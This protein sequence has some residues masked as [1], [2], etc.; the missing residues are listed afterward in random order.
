MNNVSALIFPETAPANTV[1]A[2][3]LLFFDTLSFYLP[4]EPA[5]SDAGENGLF[6]SLCS[7]YAPA[8]LGEDL[9]RFRRLLRDLETSRP[10]E[11]SRL[12]SAA[13]APVATVLVRDRDETSAAG[14]YTALHKDAEKI[15]YNSRKERLWQARLLLKLAEVL[16]RREAEV[17]EGL[18]LVSSAEQQV[19]AALGGPDETF[20]DELN[21]LDG[22]GEKLAQEAGDTPFNKP[23]PPTSRQLVNLRVKAWAELYL[24]DKTPSPPLAL[25]SANPESGAILLDGYENIWRRE[26]RKLFSLAMPAI[27]INDA[28]S[29]DRF[30]A[31]RESFRAA[32]R[33]R[34][35]YF[36]AILQEIASAASPETES[37]GW[38]A[39]AI[40]NASDWGKMLGDHFPGPE[41]VQ[42][43]DF[44]SLPG[45]S[46]T[47][48]FQRLFHLP[49]SAPVDSRPYPEA[50]LAIL[51]T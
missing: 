26:P 48:L 35:E 7:G 24:T 27:Q 21:A 34:L 6:G 33:T 50:I 32:A 29:V 16:D 30:L 39:M 9:S 31:L 3:L 2:R 12:F 19:F 14:V 38:H 42:K 5:A 22:S 41:G 20:D 17:R 18:N 47:D 44:Y 51:A 25:V 40:E 4:T 15:A 46:L 1:A 13:V 36:A 37:H 10:E 45:V 23:E 43:L 28:E 8:P 49:G 11:L